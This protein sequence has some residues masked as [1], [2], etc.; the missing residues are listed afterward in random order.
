MRKT[1]NDAAD[2]MHQGM[3]RA[4]AKANAA[5]PNWSDDAFAALSVFAKLTPDPTFLAETVREWTED[6]NLVTP[7]DNKRAWGGVFQRAAAAGLIE[8]VGYAPARS[9]NLSPKVLW[10]TTHA[11]VS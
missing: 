4:E 9:S 3:A 11:P 6:A 2:N 7:P 5:K 8:K 10:R 1:V